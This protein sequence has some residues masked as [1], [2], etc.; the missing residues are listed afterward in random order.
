MTARRRATCA[1]S[2]FRTR[3][4]PRYSK[5]MEA[6]CP[7]GSGMTYVA[8]CGPLHTGVTAARTAL[9]L[10]RSRYS[11]FVVCDAAYLLA[12]WHPAA[13]P[14]SVDFDP[15]VEWRRLRICGLTGGTEDHDE[16]MVEF[17]AHYWDSARGQYGRQHENSRFARQARRW[18]Y[19]EPTP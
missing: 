18:V 7:C 12:T 3:G 9:E 10:M 13:R 2:F 16:G 4:H 5:T 17:V 11:A 6:D 14:A 15:A 8:C 19:I 1:S